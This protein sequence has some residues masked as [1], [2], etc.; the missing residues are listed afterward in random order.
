LIPANYIKNN[1]S[2][3]SDIN[4]KIKEISKTKD[5]ELDKFVNDNNTLSTLLLHKLTFIKL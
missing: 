3:D 2:S 5:E 1:S 4:K